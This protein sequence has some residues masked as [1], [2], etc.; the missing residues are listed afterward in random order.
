MAAVADIERTR[1]LSRLKAE[2]ILLG[3]R[4]GKVAFDQSDGTWLHIPDF[5]IPPDWNTDIV[6]LLID[7]PHATPGGYP[8]I[9]PQWFWTNDDLRTKNGK[10]IGHF[11]TQSTTFVDQ[12]HRENNWGHFCLHVNYWQPSGGSNL[13][14]GHSLLT[15]VDLI[16]AVF[17][18]WRT[19]SEE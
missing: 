9:A 4:Y 10:S 17:R 15:Y 16:G 8:S 5:P 18:D 6:E 7:I 1:R 13:R 3:R 11:F 19:L 2:S 14:A 12:G